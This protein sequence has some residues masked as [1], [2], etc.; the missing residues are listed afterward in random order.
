MGKP[1]QAGRMKNG[2]FDSAH[3]FCFQGVRL[4]AIDATPTGALYSGWALAPLP[5]PVGL[6][7]HRGQRP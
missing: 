1:A 6:T 3:I 4:L 2:T 7:S 5:F